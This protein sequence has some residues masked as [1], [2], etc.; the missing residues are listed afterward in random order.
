LKTDLQG[1]SSIQSEFTAQWLQQQ[2]T[3][4]NSISA[5][6][7]RLSKSG[8]SSSQSRSTGGLQKPFSDTGV[9]DELRSTLETFQSEV[10]D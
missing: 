3:Q 7:E 8:I 1:H 6:M 4:L 5:S 10:S 9:V 2:S